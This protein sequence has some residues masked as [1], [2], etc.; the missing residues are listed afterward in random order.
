MLVP[1]LT[2]PTV[3]PINGRRRFALCEFLRNG[4][5]QCFDVHEIGSISL[6]DRGNEPDQLEALKG[7]RGGQYSIRVNGQWRVGFGFA[8][9]NA[10]DVEIV[11]YH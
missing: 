1:R 7:D 10:T 2:F 4:R 8:G 11:D 9:G 6:I 3:D 5:G